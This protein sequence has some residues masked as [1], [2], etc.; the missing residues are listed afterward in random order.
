MISSKNIFKSILSF[1]FTFS[2]FFILPFYIHKSIS[3]NHIALEFLKNINTIYI[4]GITV[5]IFSTIRWLFNKRL[6][7]ILSILYVASLISYLYYIFLNSIV[8]AKLNNVE[9]IINY[10]GIVLIFMFLAFSY[11][12]FAYV[13]YRNDFND[14]PEAI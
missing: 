11:I 10:R 2:I 1:L 12:V 4:L 13:R 5:I 7:L 9:I 8:F 3:S 14:N 6:G